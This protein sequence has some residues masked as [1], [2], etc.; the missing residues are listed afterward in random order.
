M[1]LSVDR[2]LLTRQQKMK[3]YKQ[4]VCPRLTWLLTVDEYPLTWIERELEVRATRCLKRWAGLAKS[5]NTSLLYL[6]LKDDGLNLPSISSIYK[7]LQVSKKCQLLTSADP[8]VR[9]IAEEDLKCELTMRR[10]KF[11]PA[12]VARQALVED[13]GRSRAALLAA[14]KRQVKSD[15]VTTHLAEL[16][17][18]EKQGHM[19]GAAP[20]DAATIWS[21]AVQ[22]LPQ[23]TLKFAF[24]ASLDTLLHN[25]NLHLWKKRSSSMCQLCHHPNQSLIHV[26][27]NCSMALQL[28][29]Y[30]ERHD[31]VLK[32]IANSIQNSLPSTTKLTTDLRGEYL[33]P[34]HIAPT[35]LHPDI[36]W[37]DDTSR[38]ITLIELTVCFESCF[39]D[40]KQR[41]EDRYADLLHALRRAQYKACLVT[42]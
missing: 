33:F 14:A 40:A 2:A 11:L 20:T 16:T 18:L 38:T 9:R 34:S 3:L 24:N 17:C 10:K 25:N 28:R 42:H 22:A 29:S 36:V 13:P 7:S 32:V 31:G 23:N 12:V 35:D 1:L 27:N 19:L 21:K 4:A 30:N 26:L 41:K 39:D 8:T 5:A 6:T 37:W 15:D